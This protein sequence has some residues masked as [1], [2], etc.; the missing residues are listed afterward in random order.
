IVAVGA[1]VWQRLA[2]GGSAASVFTVHVPAVG[3]NVA[4][5]YGPT[6][7]PNPVG[8]WYGPAGTI[9]DD[10]RLQCSAESGA[11][12]VRV[13]LGWDRVETTQ[14]VYDFSGPDKEFRLLATR[15]VRP[16][17]NIVGAPAFAAD[18][19]C[20]PFKPGG[21]ALFTKFVSEAVKRYSVAPYNVKR[22]ILYN[23]P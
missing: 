16:V 1:V 10:A 2:D 3:K 14:G 6:G 23:E 22:W 5:D 20:G 11:T 13:F 8:I 18:P 12:W 17:I 19:A 21:L 15:G 7:R 9:T 4:C